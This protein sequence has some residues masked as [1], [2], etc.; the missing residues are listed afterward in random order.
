MATMKFLIPDMDIPSDPDHPDSCE[1]VKLRIPLEKYESHIG[2]TII[3]RRVSDGADLGYATIAGFEEVDEGII[4][5]YET[6]IPVEE[7][8]IEY[9][10]HIVVGG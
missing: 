4:M 2:T 7:L 1:I 8:A 6:D 9:P 5:V 3:L 10:H